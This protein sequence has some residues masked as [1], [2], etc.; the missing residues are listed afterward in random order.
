MIRLALAMLVVSA[1]SADV[2]SDELPPADPV[3][4]LE[5]LIWDV[6]G[7]AVDALERLAPRS[8]TARTALQWAMYYGDDDLRW[9]AVQA[10]INIGGDSR[11]L[12]PLLGSQDGFFRHY[13]AQHLLR[14]E[15][16]IPD[17][18]AA[19][20][21]PD[22]ASRPAL[23][24]DAEEI[25]ESFSP[26]L[27]RAAVPRLLDALGGDD[28]TTRFPAAEA[29]EVLPQIG[30]ENVP[31]LIA[32]LG[33]ARRDVQNN[34]ARLLGNLAR[35]EIGAEHVPQLVTLLD[36]ARP[37]VSMAA[38]RI[39]G[40][41]GPTA[42]AA[43]PP[44]RK[45]L[46][47][48][49]GEAAVTLAVALGRIQPDDPHSLPV[50]VRELHAGM[51]SSGDA[52][53]LLGSVGRAAPGVVPALIDVL[54]SNDRI[55][56]LRT[57]EALKRLGRAAVPELA[58]A[59]ERHPH[60]IARQR[61]AEVLGEIGPAADAAVPVLIH[62]AGDR[63]STLRVTA[64]TALAEIGRA[65][66]P[67]VPALVAGL[68]DI[69]STV[70]VAAAQ[71]LGVVGPLPGAA[72]DA[73]WHALDDA[74]LD[75]RLAAA[76]ALSQQGEPAGRLLPVVV[77]LL[78]DDKPERCQ[79]ALRFLQTLGPAA[80]VAAPQ[81]VGALRLQG[82]VSLG[83]GGISTVP[84]V[85]ETLAAV[86]PAAVPALA[87]ALWS[88]DPQMRYSAAEAL[89]RIG[90]A[91][92]DAVPALRAHIHDRKAYLVV[93]GCMG[94]DS[95]VGERAVE[96]LGEIGPAAREAIPDL[97]ALTTGT[98]PKWASDDEQPFCAAVQALQQIG[99]GNKQVA[100]ALRNVLRR[101][102]DDTSGDLLVRVQIA[103]ACVT[104][105]PQ[106]QLSL[107]EDLLT[108]W[109]K[110]ECDLRWMTDSEHIAELI[111]RLGPRGQHLRP[112]LREMVTTQPL[113]HPYYRCNAALALARLDPS[114]PLP[115]EYLRHAAR[116]GERYLV[117]PQAR[118]ALE[119]LPTYPE[120]P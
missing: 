46:A 20:L 69:N 62:V 45:A 48:A 87:D 83:W 15:R 67:A 43:V 27:A 111:A 82:A 5:Q 19:L 9:W 64:M 55:D 11:A 29:L 61:A 44:L 4:V 109:R 22:D 98:I 28:E 81:L 1:L 85:V 52:I 21:I 75:V 117:A 23:P 115:R 16:V 50:L 116:Y 17:A 105:D 41:L 95:S 60:Q 110:A 24:G 107:A 92:A 104:P 86:G 30:A 74:D 89:G 76:Q 90:P 56:R 101:A 54:D 26:R 100:A 68:A 10:W 112:I 51:E 42:R 84:I 47:G 13:V 25:F 119:S 118:Q 3:V 32:L 103:L 8:P 113:L 37:N 7:A 33:D 65:A 70:R 78:T 77:P 114:D 99:P 97:I 40:T 96:S 6:E 120:S 34:A 71:A 59:V 102:D 63:R 108:Q 39:L 80:E 93:S 38:A 72:R 14:Q 58:C 57:R 106:E 49:T 36:D 53:A 91:A 35:S 66:N 2:R 12:Q 73:L 31:R 18:V 79:Q 94:R 88:A